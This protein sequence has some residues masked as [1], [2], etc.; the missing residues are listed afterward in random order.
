MPLRIA[1]VAGA[2]PNFMK[3]RPV[4]A[5][6]ESRGVETL[7]VHT[8]Q[9]YDAAMSDVFFADLGIRAPDYSLGVG[10]GTHAT[11]TARIMTAFEEVVDHT[12]PDVVAVVGDV[13]STVACALVAAKA[14]SRVA[15][16]E[17]G[18]R[19]RDWAMPEEINRVVT[20]RLSD[21]L[22][23]PSQDAVDNLRS[24]GYRADQVHL[25]GNVMIDCLLS[26][27][28]RATEQP[29]RA[30]LGV[31]TGGYVLATLHRP[32]NV[33]DAATLDRIV[34]A[35]VRLSERVPVLFPVHPR[36]RSRLTS[37]PLGDVRLLEPLGYLDF[38]ALEAQAG[39]VITDSGGIQ[40]ETTVLGVPCLTVR[41]NTERPIT[42][43]EGTN[44]VVG[45]STERIY[46]AAVAVLQDRPA[47]RR[48]VLWD[49]KAADR[50]ADVLVSPGLPGRPTDLP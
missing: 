29:V 8:G 43:T 21:Y 38:V 14:G 24:E 20:D 30:E 10:S 19:S 34:T 12:R 28:E 48:P 11:Q 33:D 26:N 22:F 23:A 50:I 9:H 17:A 35:L 15:H 18:L 49:G 3:V 13:N 42:V 45:T 47:A 31:E 37:R 4:L 1:C 36:T 2:R 39:V 27:L 46:A 41:E 5:A 25:V 16:V 40:E 6:L 7:L 44:Q 32:S